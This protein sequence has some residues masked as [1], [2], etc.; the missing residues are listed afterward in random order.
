MTGKLSALYILFIVTFSLFDLLLL[1]STTRSSLCIFIYNN[2]LFR[3]GTTDITRTVHFGEPTSEEVECFTRVLKGFIAL[4]T[5]V[6]PRKTQVSLRQH[7]WRVYLLLRDAF[8]YFFQRRTII[9]L[10]LFVVKDLFP[11]TETVKYI[12]F[13]FN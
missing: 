7:L 9:I 12:S 13:L 8:L 10:Q 3:D 5:S 4:V 11:E 2:F 1:H 6:F